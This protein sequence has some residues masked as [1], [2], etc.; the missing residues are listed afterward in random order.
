M[1]RR[2]LTEAERKA[3]HP[4]QPGSKDKA[5]ADLARYMDNPEQ[6]MVPHGKADKLAETRHMNV[7]PAKMFDDGGH[8]MAVIAY[9]AARGSQAKP[10]K[11]K[12]E[13]FATFDEYLTFCTENKVPPTVAA[14]AVWNGV[15]VQRM[16][17]IE[18]DKSD[19]E[20]A[21][22]YATVKECIRT[23]HELSAIDSTVNLLYFFHANKVYFGAIETNAQVNVHIDDNTAEISDDEY[24]ERI[25]M[26]QGDDGVFRPHK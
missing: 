18:R 15:T 13:T 10:P 26:L 8:K 4:F 11:T 23:L 1:S 22:A 2:K 5:L 17:Q 25:T 14:W 20:R 3:R 16:N 9:L 7:A 19:N 24:R 12:A 6:P 21:Q